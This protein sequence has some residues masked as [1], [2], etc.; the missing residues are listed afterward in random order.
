[1]LAARSHAFLARFKIAW[2]K[3]ERSPVR[4]RSWPVIVT[5]AGMVALNGALAVAKLRFK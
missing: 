1:M 4:W 3:R 2:K 5:N